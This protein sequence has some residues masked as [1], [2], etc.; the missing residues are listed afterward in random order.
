MG[1]MKNTRRHVLSGWSKIL[2]FLWTFPMQIN[3]LYVL[4]VMKHENSTG[5]Q[6]KKPIVS[7]LYGQT[8]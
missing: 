2:N 7:K 8:I 4:T 1:E 3:D 6:M 5:L